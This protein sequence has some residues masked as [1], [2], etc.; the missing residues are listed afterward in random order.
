MWSTITLATFHPH[1]RA[2]WALTTFSLLLHLFTATQYLHTIC[3]I[4]SLSVSFK[5]RFLRVLPTF[6]FPLL[7]I[8]VV[9]FVWKYKNCNFYQLKHQHKSFVYTASGLL[10]FAYNWLVFCLRDCVVCKAQLAKL[11]MKV[12][13]GTKVQILCLLM[14]LIMMKIYFTIPASSTSSTILATSGFSSI[15]QLQGALTIHQRM[16][17]TKI[18]ISTNHHFHHHQ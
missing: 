7:L 1:H 12:S 8:N 10:I 5:P 15:L 16:K 11:K 2:F 13:F 17:P 18:F 4:P 14:I 3:V 9:P 6:P